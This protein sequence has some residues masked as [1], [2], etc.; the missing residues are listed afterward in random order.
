MIKY[1][2]LDILVSHTGVDIVPIKDRP[3]AWGQAAKG[4]VDLEDPEFVAAP[5]TLGEANGEHRCLGR[6][7]KRR[8]ARG[9][10]KDS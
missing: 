7:G 5:W 3:N 10:M 4:I 1:I 6:R 9:P 2:S 8:L